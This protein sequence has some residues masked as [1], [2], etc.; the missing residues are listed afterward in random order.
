MLPGWTPS[1]M[2]ISQVLSSSIVID[3][4]LET[5]L[6]DYMINHADLV[7]ITITIVYIDDVLQIFFLTSVFF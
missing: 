7:Q 4:K 3:L 6:Q 2:Q 5:R 1:Y